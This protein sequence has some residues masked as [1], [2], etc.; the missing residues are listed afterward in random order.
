MSETQP[1]HSISR[2][3]ALR[4]MACGFGYMAAA[5]IA[6][7]AAAAGI[8]NPLLPKIPHIIPKAKRVIFLFMAGGVSQVDS[9]DYKPLLYKDDGR[10]L[11]FTDQRILAKTGMGSNQRV[12][13]PLWD[14]KQRGQNG[15]W[16]SELFPHMAKHTD[17][18]CIIR[19][20]QTEG[21]AHGPATLF[22]HTGSTNLIRPSMGSWVN[23]GLGTESQDMPGFVS[24]SPSMGNGGPRNYGNAFLPASYQGT[25]I[26]RAGM[27]ATD[28]GIKNLKNETLSSD[29]QR[30]QFE[31]LQA[32]HHERK[33][34]LPGNTELEAVINSYEL[35]W[36]MQSNAP[37]VLDMSK[38]TEATKKLYGIDEEP[39]DDYGR[40]CLMAR[41]MAES[42]VRFIQVNYSDN[43]NNPA[44]DQHNDMPKHKEH[45][46]AVD[47]PIS[48]LLTDLKQR[49]LLQDTLVWW[50]GEFGRT[51]YAQKNG[52]GRDHNP[53]GF[54]VWLAGGGV[55]PGLI[56]GE[57]DEFGQY[58]VQNQ[59]HMHDLHA[60]ILHLLGMDHKR[61]TFRHEGRDFRLTDVFGNVVHDIIT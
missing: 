27:K 46:L 47:K 8:S 5:G 37:E 18:Y 15:A 48:G 9:Y 60:T 49:G 36:R 30:R 13:K 54:T 3:D 53:T 51:P 1:V 32:M 38:E 57:T 39:T 41:R 56:Y 6:Q 33:K 20:M 2:R 7:Q 14:F 24:L 40:Q 50:G 55:R 45:A 21:V 17:D 25:A 26:G 19:S 23:Y 10:M 52:D 4:H 28:I 12:M 42:G 34:S 59:V 22:L 29:Q 11:D 31:L 35:A 43:S 44:W 16:V 61:L 58:A